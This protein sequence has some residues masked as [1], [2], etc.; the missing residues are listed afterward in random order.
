MRERVCK[1]RDA[2]IFILTLMVPRI[3]HA[4]SVPM[5]KKRRESKAF[6]ITQQTAVLSKSPVIFLLVM[7][8]QKLPPIDTCFAH[9]HYV[10][11]KGRRFWYMECAGFIQLSEL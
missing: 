9:W 5:Q 3:L 1:K 10:L 8:F 6:K 4:L 11:T 7:G 2:F